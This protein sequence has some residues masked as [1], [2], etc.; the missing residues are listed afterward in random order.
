MDQISL[1]IMCV[2][3]S[4]NLQNSLPLMVLFT[5][6]LLLCL[7]NRLHFHTYPMLKKTQTKDMQVLN[8]IVVQ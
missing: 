5:L 2:G 1:H 8:I 6:L 3:I 7:L 4:L